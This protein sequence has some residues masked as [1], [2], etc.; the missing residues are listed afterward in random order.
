MSNLLELKSINDELAALKDRVR[1]LKQKRKLLDKR[2]KEESVKDKLSKLNLDKNSFWQLWEFNQLSSKDK[3]IHY[4]FYFTL[5]EEEQTHL[6]FFIQKLEKK[7]KRK[8]FSGYNNI[9]DFR[10]ASSYEEISHIVNFYPTDFDKKGNKQ[11]FRYSFCEPTENDT[12]F[13]ISKY[14]KT[15]KEMLKF[16]KKQKNELKKLRQFKIELRHNFHPTLV[17]MVEN[18]DQ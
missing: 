18:N 5:N 9:L 14:E 8:V 10:L 1:D 17:K 13:L 4:P 12:N 16:E 6:F 15:R 7:L 3:I 11:I 2:T